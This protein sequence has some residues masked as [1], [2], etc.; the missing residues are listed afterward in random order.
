MASA[1]FEELYE[2]IGL[3]DR[4]LSQ[5]TVFVKKMEHVSL[6]NS[7]GGKVTCGR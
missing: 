7:F 6:G 4:D 2:P 1:S 3:F 5:F